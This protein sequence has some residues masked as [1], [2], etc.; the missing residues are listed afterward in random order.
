LNKYNKNVP[1]PKTKKKKC[2]IIRV[3]VRGKIHEWIKTSIVY[4]L[5]AIIEIEIQL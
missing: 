2:W 5:N 3:K 4:S 1:K